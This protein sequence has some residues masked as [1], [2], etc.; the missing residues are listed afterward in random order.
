R[1]SHFR[2]QGPA[3]A[4]L[5]GAFMDNWIKARGEVLHSDR[6]FPALEP[7]GEHVCQVL[8]SSPDGGS[9][10][11]RLMFL[12]AITAASH[13]IRIGTAYFVPDA[14]ATE[15]LLAARR[16]GGRVQIIVPG[17][18]ND[19]GLVRLVSRDRY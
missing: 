5:Q 16:R 19:E 13:S 15:T 9:D 12:L 4:A 2:V 8:Q 17:K 10:S 6:Y 18:Y 3:V 11:V 7:A 14:L 1:D